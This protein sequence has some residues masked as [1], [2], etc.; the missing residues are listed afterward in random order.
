MNGCTSITYR[1]IKLNGAEISR[2]VLSRDTYNPMNKIIQRGPTAQEQ[3]QPVI[4]EPIQTE[5]PVDTN[6]NTNTNTNTEVEDTN[7]NT[8]TN[9][10]GENTNTEGE[11]TNTNT[12]ENIDLG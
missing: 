7:T 11:N 8:N 6:T 2:E 1:V 5:E 9:T 12:N 10:G 4:E 3:T